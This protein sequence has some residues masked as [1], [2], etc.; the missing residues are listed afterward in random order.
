MTIPNVFVKNLQ[1][2]DWS[3]VPSIN[4]AANTISVANFIKQSAADGITLE[5]ELE[6]VNMDVALDQVVQHHT[7]IDRN[8]TK[9]YKVTT[10]HNAGI[11]LSSLLEF[12]LNLADWSIVKDKDQKENLALCNFLEHVIDRLLNRQG[13][14]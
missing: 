10:V 3:M 6:L 14:A 11:T 8:L 13:L 9:S 1:L 2:C 12:L 4:E 5:M 7:P